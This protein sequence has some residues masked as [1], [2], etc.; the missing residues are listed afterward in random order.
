MEF[1]L[2]CTKIH[3]SFNCICF[4]GTSCRN[5]V[6]QNADAVSHEPVNLVCLHMFV[7]VDAHMW[8]QA[9]FYVES[10]RSETSAQLV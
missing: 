9:N 5:R 6:F 8:L 4:L 10:Q 3:L 1:K 2:L 7:F